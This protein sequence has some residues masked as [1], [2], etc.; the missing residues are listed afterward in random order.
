[1]ATR[2]TLATLTEEVQYELGH[3]ASPSAGQNF[4][5]HIKSRI[6]REYRRLYH[7]HNWRHLRARTDIAMVAGQRYYDY[8]EAAELETIIEMHVKWSGTWNPVTDDMCE[9]DYN[10][11]DS[12]LGVRT[13][14]IQKWRPYDVD[15]F[16]VWPLPASAYTLRVVTK[17]PFTQLV[18][19]S[20]RCDLD[21][22]LVVLHVAAEL[23][24]KQDDK[25]AAL[26]LGRASQHYD[27]LKSRAR[28]SR[29][30][31]N[32]AGGPNLRQTGFRDKII[33]GV[34]GE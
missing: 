32:L 16:E 12:D 4:R 17:R 3:V 27:T 34:T 9:M 11:F 5:E 18:E 1:M 31:I 33:V 2:D 15:Q 26:V 10:A 21:T 28:A 22:D 13:D 23:L 29:R 20:D 6:R 30:T 24:R 14:P 7:D 8:P 25:E 19:E